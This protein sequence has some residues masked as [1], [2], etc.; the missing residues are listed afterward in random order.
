MKLISSQA[1]LICSSETPSCAIAVEGARHGRVVELILV[2]DAILRCLHAVIAP[3]RRI[4]PKASAHNSR[5]DAAR[6]R[7]VDQTGSRRRAARACLPVIL[8]I[9]RNIRR[10]LGQPMR[11]RAGTHGALR[12]RPFAS[13]LQQKVVGPASVGHEDRQTS[14]HVE[15]QGRG[16]PKAR[17]HSSPSKFNVA[18]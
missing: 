11:R 15:S 2:G 13:G 18:P 10:G 7:E 1:A 14:L 5:R 8:S 9:R 17:G 12:S 6:V 3:L 16:R 4:W